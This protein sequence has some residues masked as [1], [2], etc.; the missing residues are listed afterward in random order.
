MV[1]QIFLWNY[2]C[3]M[4][5]RAVSNMTRTRNYECTMGFRAISNLAPR[6]NSIGRLLD[7][8]TRTC[9]LRFGRRKREHDNVWGMLHLGAADDA[10]TNG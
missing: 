2:E 9:N 8:Y 5:S 3:T 7:N 6:M 1:Y 4:G 10:D